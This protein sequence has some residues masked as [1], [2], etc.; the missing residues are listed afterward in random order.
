MTTATFDTLSDKSTRILRGL[1]LTRLLAK[2]NRA[3]ETSAD[4]ARGF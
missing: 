1:W 3:L 4:G 2:L